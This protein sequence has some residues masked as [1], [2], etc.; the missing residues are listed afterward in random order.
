[1]TLHIAS[2]TCFHQAMDELNERRIE[3]G[4]T[5]VKYRELAQSDRQTIWQRVKELEHDSAPRE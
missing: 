2:S 3:E 4:F 5:P 1:M